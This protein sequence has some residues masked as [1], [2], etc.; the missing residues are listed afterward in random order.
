MM[1][2]DMRT[3]SREILAYL[4]VCDILSNAMIIWGVAWSSRSHSNVSS[5]NVQCQVQA[6]ILIYAGIAEYLWTCALAFYL[7]VIIVRQSLWGS[8]MCPRIIHLACWGTGFI[9]AP[10]AFGLKKTGVDVQAR[11]TAQWCILRDAE[12]PK[13]GGDRNYVIWSFLVGDGWGFLAIVCTLVFYILIKRH[14]YLQVS[15]SLDPVPPTFNKNMHTSDVML[16]ET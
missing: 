15:V 4:S 2:T 8:K 5:D 16:S 12:D 11:N 7:F 14:I 6:V 9:I 13:M 3:T 1:Y 10:L